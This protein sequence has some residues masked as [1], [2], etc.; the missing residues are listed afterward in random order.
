MMPLRLSLGR[1]RIARLPAKASR[2][3]NSEQ[4]LR[5]YSI[6]SINIIEY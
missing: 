6:S 2:E 5:F 4:R 3:C 1:R